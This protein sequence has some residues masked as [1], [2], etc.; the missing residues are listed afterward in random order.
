MRQI[1]ASL[2]AAAFITLFAGQG[3]PASAEQPVAFR[4]GGYPAGTIVVRTSERKLYL[5]L[6][7]ERALRYPV[8]VGKSGKQWFGRRAIVAKFLKPAWMPPA[9]VKHDVP[10]IPGL[11]RRRDASQSRWARPPWY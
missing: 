10:N 8:G 2:A 7:H 6:G 9:E 11:Y 5:V 3:S 4:G 1:Q